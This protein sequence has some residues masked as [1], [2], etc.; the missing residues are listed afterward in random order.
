MATY[1]EMPKLSDTMTE[2]TLVKWRKKKG[3]KVESG[4]I[5]AEVETDKATMEMEAFD[6][7]ILT[8]LYINEGQKVAVGQRM[9]LLLAPGEKAPEDSGGAPSTE[10]KAAT[11]GE[12]GKFDK[13]E[14]APAP[15]GAPSGGKAAAAP[16]TG[17]REQQHANGGHATAAASGGRIKASPLAKKIAAQKGIDLSQLK[18]SGPGGRIVQSDVLAA[19]QGGT[20]PAPAPTTGRAAAHAAPAGPAAIPA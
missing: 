5:L 12:P 1:I 14:A 4:D 7:G 18:G 16:A 19:P 2:G 9:A 17:G 10:A 15:A 8:E 13:R 20:A 6:D 3:D 11:G